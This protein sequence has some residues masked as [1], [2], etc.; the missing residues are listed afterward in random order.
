MVDVVNIRLWGEYVGAAMWNPQTQSAAFEFD[1]SFITKGLDISPIVMPVSNPRI[2]SFG[3]ISQ[4]T[5]MGL[6]GLLAD[7]LP[8]SYGRKLLDRWLAMNGRTVANPI[9]LLCFQGKRGMGALEFEPAES[10]FPD[11]NRAIEISTLIDVAQQITSDKESLSA[12]FDDSS[13][14]EGIE[15][16]ISVGTSAGGMRAKA[17]IAYNEA[18]NE[19]RSGQIDAGDGFEHWLLKLDGVTNNELGDPKHYGLIEYLYYLMAKDAG[20]EMMESK[21]LREGSR[22]HFMT[23]RFDRVG[24]SEKLHTQ[25]LCGLAHYDYRVLRAYSYEQLFEVMRRLRLPLSEAKE[26]FRRMVFNIVARNQDDHTKNVSFVMNRSGAWSLS[27]AYDVT[28]AYSPNGSWTA[29]HQMSVNGKWDGFTRRDLSEF[30]AKMNIKNYAEIIDQVITSVSRWQILSSEYELPRA[31]SSR[32][33]SH[34]LLDL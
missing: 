9:E 4:Q 15:Q 29:M 11:K 23:K 14:K 12:S 20:I 26:M 1:K 30:A 13:L 24:A 22:A 6:P 28:W 27:P 17:V 16:V 8:D 3:D 31:I 25:T 33:F 34:F 18:T 7:S 19:V 5:F 21:L 10:I 2:F 32:L